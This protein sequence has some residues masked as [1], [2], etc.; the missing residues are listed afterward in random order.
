MTSPSLLVSPDTRQRGGFGIKPRQVG[1]QK[2]ET[3]GLFRNRS[4]MKR[5]KFTAASARYTGK[6]IEYPVGA[7]LML[8]D[9]DLEELDLGSGAA[10]MSQ[11]FAA[12]ILSFR[13]LP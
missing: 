10:K 1:T 5:Q 13:T 8:T 6:N 9:R 3:S 11:L 2:Q 4:H 12:S 7:L